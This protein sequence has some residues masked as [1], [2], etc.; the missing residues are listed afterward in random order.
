[1]FASLT[2]ENLA[3]LGINAFGA[4][5]RLLYAINQLNAER[6]LSR[7]LLGKFSGSAAPGAERRPSSGW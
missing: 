3:E 7:P 4:R 5:K 6:S 2:V 1:M